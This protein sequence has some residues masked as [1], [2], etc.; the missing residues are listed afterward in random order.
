MGGCKQSKFVQESTES[1]NRNRNRDSNISVN[2]HINNRHI[3]TKTIPANDSNTIIPVPTQIPEQIQLIDYEIDSAITIARQ[4]DEDRVKLL[5][6]GIGESGK[7]TIFKQ[8]R[9]LYGSDKSED[10]LRMYGVVVR[11]NIITAVQK[12]CRLTK[13]MG[14]EERLDQESEAA[15]KMNE[16][17]TCGMT[18]REA[19]DQLVTY[20][21]GLD[22]QGQSQNQSQTG[23]TSFNHHS[24]HDNNNSKNSNNN[25]ANPQAQA[26]ANSYPYPDIISRRQPENDWVGKSPWAGAQNNENARLFLQHVE[27][28]RILWQVSK[29]CIN[30][31]IK[32]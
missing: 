2:T 6:L 32:T 20:V 28:I 26:Q 22:S 17:D 23:S 3:N 16:V 30:Y 15:S 14:Y 18:V 7:S 5:L 31:E 8:F 27:A 9:I 13:E 19:Y 29:R 4:L 12:L 1:R 10:D 24:N 11:S 21:V 25:A